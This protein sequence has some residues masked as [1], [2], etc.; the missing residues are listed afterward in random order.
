MDVWRRVPAPALAG[1]RTLLLAGVLT[2]APAGRLG[3]LQTPSDHECGTAE[4]VPRV[5]FVVQYVKH[6]PDGHAESGPGTAVGQWGSSFIP[7]VSH[8]PQPVGF[9][10][11][12]EE[13]DAQDN[14]VRLNIWVEENY[15]QHRAGLEG[16]EFATRDDVGVTISVGRM[17]PHG[18]YVWVSE[19][20]EWVGSLAEIDDLKP[21][22]QGEIE[23]LHHF[24]I[25]KLLPTKVSFKLTWHFHDVEDPIAPIFFIDAMEDSFGPIEPHPTE[26]NFCFNVHL[27]HYDGTE[28]AST[29]AV[30]EKE[31]WR[32]DLQ[33]DIRPHVEK[34]CEPREGYCERPEASVQPYLTKG[35]GIYWDDRLETFD[36][37]DRPITFVCPLEIEPPSPDTL[38]LGAPERRALSFKV[39]G[40]EG[41]PLPGVDVEVT[42][43]VAPELGQVAPQRMRTASTGEPEGL[44]ITTREDAPPE[45]VDQV[46]VA[47][48][49]DTPAD[50]LGKDES[51]RPIPW[52]DKATQTVKVQVFPTVDVL[53]RAVH[54]LDRS[55]DKRVESSAEVS[56][57]LTRTETDQTLELTFQVVLGEREVKRDYRD[58]SGFRGTLIQYRGHAEARVGLASLE[59]SKETVQK[60]G[61]WEDRECGRL[62]FDFLPWTNTYTFRQL[63]DRAN[64]LVLYQHFIPDEGSPVQEH[65]REGLSYTPRSLAPV[66]TFTPRSIDVNM[67]QDGCR[68]DF[69]TMRA[70]AMQVPLQVNEAFP[71]L[72]GLYMDDCYGLEEVTVPLKE[73]D[74]MGALL[75]KWDPVTREFDEIE[76]TVTID[77]GRD[78]TAEC[79]S[80]P[81]DTPTERYIPEGTR[82]KGLWSLS[83]QARLVGGNFDFR[84][85]PPR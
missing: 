2:L 39:T 26:R 64:L 16:A 49:R 44:A 6:L 72:F 57:E 69:E 82:V 17:G 20:H 12:L 9:N 14:Y 19:K 80:I 41:M 55:E 36:S 21:F 11:I 27:T 74:S 85:D 45:A 59:P 37:D 83:S 77:L 71:I 70:P 62:T 73:E 1:V 63:A 31:F 42:R 38:F 8:G 33:D 54:R 81:A 65:P 7:D 22:I 3:A 68:L 13:D 15:M 40:L 61:Y 30:D 53:V 76:R 18:H 58:G 35:F 78:D 24:M 4:D 50:K 34:A 46:E 47:V 29:V 51:G 28:L 52:T 25:T 32:Y 56:R 23:G 67:E 43:G 10:L 84:P 5:G 66:V 60:S 48:C 75:R 79:W